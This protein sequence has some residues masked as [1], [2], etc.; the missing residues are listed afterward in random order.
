MGEG[1]GLRRVAMGRWAFPLG[2]PCMEAQVG[3]GACGDPGQPQQPWRLL[4]ALEALSL[5]LLV[6]PLGWSPWGAQACSGRPR[7]QN[8]A[9]AL[10]LP[11]A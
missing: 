8:L 3:V 11:P 1:G 7:P 10:Y 9:R 2:S 4:G 5:Q 6:A